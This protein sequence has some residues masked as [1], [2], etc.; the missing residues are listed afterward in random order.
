MTIDFVTGLPK[1]H[2]YGQI[3]DMILI[4]INHLSKK[5]YYILCLE[6]KEG[7]SAEATAELFMQ[8]VWLRQDLPISLTSDRGLQFTAK[9]WDSLCKLLGIKAKLSTAWH[10]EIDGQNKIANQEME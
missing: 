5:R 6:D 7:T 8:Y 1:C 10:P 4:V 2:V 3:Y 9:I